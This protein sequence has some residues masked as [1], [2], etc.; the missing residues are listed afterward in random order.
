MNAIFF[1]TGLCRDTY[2]W[3]VP[4]LKAHGYLVCNHTYSHPVLTKLAN[5]S[6]AAEIAGGVHAGCNLFRPPYGAWD[7]PR[8]RIAAI[9]ASQGYQVLMWDVDTRDWAGT[10]AQA[11]VAGIHARGGIVLMHMHGIHTVEAILSL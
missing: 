6:I 4:T 9:A 1:P 10:S 2:P 11:M 8:G 3:L 5:R 7:G